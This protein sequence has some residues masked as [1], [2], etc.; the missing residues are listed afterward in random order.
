M[1]GAVDSVSSMNSVYINLCCLL[2]DINVHVVV[3]SGH[4]YFATI[5]SLESQL[6]D[7]K[8]QPAFAIVDLSTVHR[9]KTAAAQCFQR[10]VCDLA[11]RSTVLVLCGVQKGFR[12]HADF[13][14]AGVDLIFDSEK[15]GMGTGKGILSFRAH[16]DA[17]TWCE[18]QSEL[19]RDLCSNLKLIFI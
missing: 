3:L 2:R 5:P 14:Q 10:V 16:G 1:Y 11:P 15:G 19:A 7:T 12:V 13:D 18:H 9:L 6:L 4:V 17:L 8:K